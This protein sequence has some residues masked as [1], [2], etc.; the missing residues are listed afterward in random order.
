MTIA[1]IV[2]M[3]SEAALLPPGIPVGAAGGVT[4]RVTEL[5]ER[6]LAE[7]AEGL[8]SFG[9][10]GGL[11]PALTSGNLVVGLSVQWEGETFAADAAWA[12]RLL[13]AIPGAR[14]GTIAAVSRIAATPEAKQALYQ[15]G[16]AVVDMES[17][18]MAKVCAAAGKPFAVLR[19]VAD[20]AARG[21]PR[22][23]F[24]GLAPDGSARPWAV[25][26]A[27]LRRPW[28]LPGLIRVGLDSQAALAALR[29]AVKVVGPTL[30][31]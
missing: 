31:M 15:G 10:A 25:M 23:V 19:A 5:A 9:I 22:S 4:R 17:G 27:L 26:G 20:P 2:G 29:D 28:E 7:G 24:V 6:L 3:N 21:L 11:D 12:S 14:Q 8:L 18:A 16:A 1:V 30:G 13:T